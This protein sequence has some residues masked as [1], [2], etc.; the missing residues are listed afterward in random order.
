[1][2]GLR[3]F[4]TRFRPAG[5]PGRAAP[6][7]VPVDRSA[8]LAAELEPPLELMEQA[9]AEARALRERAAEEAD[10]LRRQAYRRAEEMVR[11]ARARAPGVQRRT[12]EE[13]VRAAERQAA[14]LVEA[15]GQEA[16]E[17]RRAA[18]A[19]MGTVADRAV[20]LVLEDT[21][22]A[23]TGGTED[24]PFPTGPPDAHDG[25]E[26]GTPHKPGH[27]PDDGPADGPGEGGPRW[28]RDG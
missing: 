21:G 1:M 20:A 6:G 12:A 8:E 19:R 15:A 5:A 14:E 28:A 9:E 27:G 22:L 17:V 16:A 4:L 10:A 23:A 13:I 7:G 2:A 11:Q 25:R 3:D 18:G 24:G 26:A